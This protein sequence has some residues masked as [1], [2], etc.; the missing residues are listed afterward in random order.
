MYTGFYGF[1]EKPFE[2][3][4]DPQFF[5]LTPSHRSVIASIIDGIKNRRGFISVIGE[6]GTGKTTLIRFLLD[7][8]DMEEKVKTALIFHTTL[9]FKE[10]LKTIFWEIDLETLETSKMALLH[11][12]NE[13]LIQMK[14][15][16]ETLW[17]ILD[18][19][20][21]LPKDVMGE[22]GMLTKLETFQIIFA[23][24]PE[25]EGKLNSQGLRQLR[26]RIRI[27]HHLGVLSEEESKDYID[28]RLRLVGSS[29]SQIFTP[30]A[31]SM[32]YSH[33][34]GIPRTTNILCDNALLMGYRLSQKRIDVDIIHEVIK[35]MKGPFLLN[36]IRSKITTVVKKFRSF[37]PRLDFLLS[38]TSLIILCFLGLAGVYLL[39]SRYLQLRPLKIW[40]NESSKSPNMITEPSSVPQPPP[41]KIVE[42]G[43]KVDLQPLPDE[44]KPSSPEF[45]QS[46]SS[47]STP[48]TS[49]SGE[50]KT[51]E[52]V[53]VKEGQTISY[54]TRK[55]YGIV[56]RTLIGL[57]LDSNPEITDI[58]LIIVDQKMKVPEITEESLVIQFPD[59]SYKIVAG[60][61]QTPDPAKLYS[62]E[63]ILKG[64][65]VEVF[66]RKV[67]PRETWYRVV[68]GK[69]DNEKE[70]LKMIG[71]LK[72]KGLLPAFGGLPEIE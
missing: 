32:I 51:N 47:L 71:L 35:N 53:T 56:N 13:Y 3:T 5:F 61:F 36:P 10:L 54:L 19:A 22:L 69:F 16:D 65:K 29:S 4:S 38:K 42:G 1:S 30:K 24:Q 50:D 45:P 2:L 21:D 58:D 26:E 67:S 55:Y 63:Q 72:E 31:I 52:I 44:L 20:Q 66:P 40:D 6:V 59:H 70:A 49:V 25:F 57:I 62:D 33:A 43:S 48:L 23:G 7:Q 11:Q 14:A 18:E 37:P 28:H 46:G 41:Q 60:T 34:R 9:T 68:I 15:K 17:V 8:L 64:Q 39:T 12:L 27:R